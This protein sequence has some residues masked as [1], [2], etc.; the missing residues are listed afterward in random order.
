MLVLLQTAGSVAGLF[1]VACR[2]PLALGASPAHVALSSLDH[3]RAFLSDVEQPRPL[4][5]KHHA[6]RFL[7]AVSRVACASAGAS[8]VARGR[9][10]QRD[11][12]ITLLHFGKPCGHART[13]AHAVM[14]AV[15]FKAPGVL[16]ED[17]LAVHKFSPCSCPSHSRQPTATTTL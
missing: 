3:V 6:S 2:P 14:R 10:G 13:L 9:V 8:A 5:V 12:R 16:D 17:C 15:Q 11:M 4:D 7:G 1:R